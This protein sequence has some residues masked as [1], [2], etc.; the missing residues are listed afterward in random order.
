MERRGADGVERRGHVTLN[1]AAIRLGSE[2]ETSLLSHKMSRR[3]TK[4][5]G[6]NRRLPSIIYTVAYRNRGKKGGRR[7]RKKQQQKKIGSK[8][9]WCG[10]FTTFSP[11]IIK[12]F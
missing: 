11:R 2:D 12:G 7:K 8:V 9:F 10:K 3:R 6:G 1:N 5:R 4:K